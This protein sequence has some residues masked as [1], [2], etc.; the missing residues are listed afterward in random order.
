MAGWVRS[1]AETRFVFLRVGIGSENEK[2][3]NSLIRSLLFPLCCGLVPGGPWPQG[4]HLTN[5]IKPLIC[6]A[7]G[8]PE[9]GLPGRHYLTCVRKGQGWACD[10]QLEA[11]WEEQRL[12]KLVVGTFT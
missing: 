3:L 10:Q 4:D 8:F 1:K 2:P 11:T 6:L 5:P 9:P 7:A 12:G